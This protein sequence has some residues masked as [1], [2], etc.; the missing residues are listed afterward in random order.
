MLR[1]RDNLIPLERRD[2][3]VYVGPPGPIADA[4]KSK[5]SVLLPTYIPAEGVVLWSGRAAAAVQN[6]TVIV[7]VAQNDGQ[8]AAV[9]AAHE[10]NRDAAVV[11]VSL[12]S[13]QMIASLPDAA[14]YICAY[15]Y[16]PPSQRAVAAVLTG[17]L[18]ARGTLPLAIPGFLAAP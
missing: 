12:G 4:V 16:L 18:P 7:C 1:N 15:G 10:A 9:Q 13:P 8:L 6:A 14:A 2:G 3:I 5:R 17:R 11:L